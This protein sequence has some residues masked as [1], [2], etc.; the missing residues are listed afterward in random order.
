VSASAKSE[1]A[2]G[3]RLFV[4]A[5]LALFLV[6][7]VITRSFAAYLAEAGPEF[8]VLIRSNQPT[9]LLN[10]AT[11]KLKLDPASKNIE[12]VDA[13]RRTTEVKKGI[14]SA[15]DLGLTDELRPVSAAPS[16]SASDPKNTAQ[17]WSWAELALYNDP[18]NARAL[19]ILGQLSQSTSDEQAKPFM[20]A[21]ARRSLQESIALYWMMRKNLQDQDYREALRN[22]DILFRTRQ[23]LMEKLGP[24]IGAMANDPR[25]NA[26]LKRVLASN[27][28]WRK[29]FLFYFVRNVSDARIPLDI[30]LS[31]KGSANP[32]TAAELSDY[33][34]LLVDKGLYDLAYYT[35]LQFLP[36]EQLGKAGHLFNGSFENA[37]SGLPF[38]WSFGQRSG[39][40]VQVAARTDQ[41]GEHALL[42]ELVPDAWLIWR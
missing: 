9:A 20:Q 24:V 12:P 28:T 2:L 15:H 41:Q 6:W 7:E 34:G 36:P 30:F 33:L 14:Q 11:E 19:R 27:P 22:M 3:R 32:L 31:L 16:Q 42:L 25:A 26:E 39:V 35:W 1:Q 10:L 8:A 4:F 40:T 21:A 29:P 17:I 37:P 5:P 23:Q 13:S 18:L 38:D